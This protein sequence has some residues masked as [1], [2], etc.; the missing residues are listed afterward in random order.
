[1]IVYND[2]THKTAIAKAANCEFK[3]T[4]P[5][6]ARVEGGKLLGGSVFE[7]YTGASMCIHVA[8]FDPRWINREILFATFHYPFV[9]LGCKI[10]FGPTPASN[11]RACK[12]NLKFGF[13]PTYRIADVFPDGDM[14]LFTMTPAQCRWLSLRV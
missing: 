13:D 14:I 6:I 1:M 3:G 11:A 7:N 5:V 4:D 9:Q 10:L 8:G 2:I 12:L